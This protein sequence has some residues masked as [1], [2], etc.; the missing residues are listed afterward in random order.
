[1]ATPEARTAGAAPNDPAPHLGRL[2][3][4]NFRNFK[5]LAC[6]L[7]EPGVA[8]IGANGSGKTNLLEAI[9]FLEVF[10]SF[11]GGPDSQLVRFGE[12]VFRIEAGLR[13]GEGSEIAAAYDRGLKR[14]KIEIDGREV[15]RVSEGIGALGV[16]VFRLEDAEIIRG[17]PGERRRYLDIVLSLTESGYL[18]ALQR[19][20][21]NLVQRNEVLRA[22][23]SAP[24]V[25]AWTGGLVEAGAR[26]LAIRSRW[27]ATGASAFRGYY[28]AIS[29]GVPGEL[30]YRSSAER[31][32]GRASRSEDPPPAAG[33]P[34]GSDEWATCLREALEATADRERRRGMTVVGPHR[35]DLR[36]AESRPGGESRDLRRY[37]SSGQ[38]RTAVL[39]LRLVE[40]DRLRE[41]LGRE[42]IYLLDDVFAELDDARSQQL[43][44]LLEDGRSGQVILTAPK[45]GDLELRGGRLERWRLLNGRIL[46]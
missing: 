39:A 25:G 12:Q 38:Q 23:G 27:V 17:S 21:A 28:E 7:P 31:A 40:A 46:S 16:S 3:L 35:D 43:L 10:R 44:E 18:A 4:R 15:E 6:E 29:G 36:F 30:S 33:R 37:G 32:K 5:E 2:S 20:R 14:K 42:P 26:M 45:A 24:E 11:R 1:M 8:I 41:R 22:G 9:H 19:Y 34:T 13:G